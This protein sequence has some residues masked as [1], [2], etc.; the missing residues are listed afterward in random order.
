M[1][2]GLQ[3]HGE[4]VGH[5]VEVRDN[6]E[7]TIWPGHTGF[8]GDISIAKKEILDAFQKMHLRTL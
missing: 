2:F 4:L 3:V 6:N 8:D 5:Y 7:A 1:Q